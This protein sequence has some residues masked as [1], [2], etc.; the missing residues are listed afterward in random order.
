MG[1]Y[2]HLALAP[3]RITPE[4]WA[5]FY[6][7]TLS[8]LACHP[9]G[10]VSRRVEKSATGT[11]ELYSRRLE[12]TPGPPEQRHWLVCGDATSRGV[13]EWFSLY[14]ALSVYER[15][16]SL[17]SPRSEPVPPAH[18]DILARLAAGQEGATARVFQERTAGLPY[19]LPMLAIAILAENR[20]PYAAYAS[21]NILLTQ[22]E[23]AVAWLQSVLDQRVELPLCLQPMR[24]WE[25]LRAFQPLTEAV[26]SFQLLFQGRWREKLSALLPGLPAEEATPVLRLALSSLPSARL[27]GA[28][29]L[30][31]E[32]LNAGGSL[33]LLLQ[34]ACLDEAGPRFAPEAVLSSLAGC[35]LTQDPSLLAQLEPPRIPPEQAN[36]LWAMILAALIELG[37]VGRQ[38]KRFMKLHEITP[39][40]QRLFP[41]RADRLARRLRDATLAQRSALVEV[42]ATE[43]ELL[44]KRFLA[45][46]DVDP[47]R[48]LHIQR[49]E[50]IP[51]S[52]APRVHQFMVQVLERQTQM[53]PVCPVPLPPE[54][55]EVASRRRVMRMLESHYALTEDAWAELE[56]DTAP[57]LLRFLVA[58]TLCD[59]YEPSYAE[60]RTILLENAA[61]RRAL[62]ARAQE[63]P[64]SAMD[65]LTVKM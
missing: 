64:P 36:G 52:L 33:E 45:A 51:D 28:Q 63:V 7:Q 4:A 41:D 1:T 54:L 23:A 8:L 29:L 55:L 53:L 25:R 35:W 11:R 9:A 57:E 30:F 38:L 20:F 56:K 17:R 32:Y 19:Q 39:I 48:L 10:L 14:R 50:E 5:D 24:L 6:D 46:R 22:A 15:Q 42:Y 2:I 43:Q 27:P 47:Q 60:M 59:H 26:C 61:L 3:D 12:F 21:G 13:A 16:L 40:L 31:I 65:F 62:V 37:P 49:L 34:T 44:E 58:L 18:T